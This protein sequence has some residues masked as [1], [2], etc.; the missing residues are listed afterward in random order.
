MKKLQARL[1]TPI[2]RR[3]KGASAVEY[4]LLVALIAVVIA[5]AVY[6]LGNTLKGKF[7]SVQQC[8]ASAT[9]NCP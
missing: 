6:L 2:A 5:G 7:T 1:R 8:V 4:G 9:G 3:D